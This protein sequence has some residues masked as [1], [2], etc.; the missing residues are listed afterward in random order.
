[1]TTALACAS[2]DSSLAVQIKT[3]IGRFFAD[4]KKAPYKTLFNPTVSG[5][6]AFNATATLRAIEVW[7]DAKKKAVKKSGPA[8]GVLVHG[9]RIL[10][11]VV[12]AKYGDAKLS[13]PIEVYGKEFKQS[14]I[15]V[16]CEGAYKKMVD[17]ISDKF[18]GKFLATLFKNPTMS[19][20]VFDFAKG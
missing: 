13:Q 20:D 4:L 18:S 8:W 9:N 19:K 16:L 5:A 11:G 15:D 6:R 7:I 14:Q 12:F 1:V 3:G 2:G 17:R 10:A